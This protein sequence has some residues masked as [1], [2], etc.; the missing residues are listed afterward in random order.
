M[1][2]ES[3]PRNLFSSLIN[4]SRFLATLAA[5]MLLGMLLFF[6]RDL[7]DVSGFRQ[8]L[9]GGLAVY[10]LATLVL[11]QIETNVNNH[12]RNQADKDTLF[13][14]YS[15]SWRFVRWYEEKAN[16]VGHLIMRSVQLLHCILLLLLIVYLAW[17]GCL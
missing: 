13:P 14:P 15:G 10:V 3:D 11:G 6:A 5:M 1:T 4:N 9:I 12:A 17:R 16:A 2:N 8:H 7:A